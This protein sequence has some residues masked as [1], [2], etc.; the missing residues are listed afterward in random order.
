MHDRN[1]SP[2]GTARP[3]AQPPE[4]TDLVE[5]YYERGY[6]DGLPLVPP[7]PAKITAVVNALGTTELDAVVITHP[8]SSLTDEE[9][10]QRIE[11]ALPQIKRIWL[12]GKASDRGL[13][14][15]DS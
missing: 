10:G 15:G 13:A 14:M 1:R 9:I 11:Q 4:G 12:A 3:R 6:S 5:W 2:P 7:T 8:L